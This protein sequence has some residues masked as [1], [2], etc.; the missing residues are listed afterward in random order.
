VPIADQA[1]QGR[2]GKRH[3]AEIGILIDALGQWLAVSAFEVAGKVLHGERFSG[4]LT[5]RKR[6]EEV[7]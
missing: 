4:T 7:S 1:W 5:K 3:R 6:G 2:T